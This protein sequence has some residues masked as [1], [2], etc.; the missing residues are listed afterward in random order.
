[1]RF[2]S[3]ELFIHRMTG[4]VAMLNRSAILVRPREPYLQWARELD[5]SGVV[6][7]PKAERTV[8]LVES[9]ED[10]LDADRVLRACFDLIFEEELGGWHTDE[11]AWPEDRSYEVFREWFDVEVDTMVVDLLDA[12]PAHEDLRCSP[13]AKAEGRRDSAASGRLCWPGGGSLV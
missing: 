10:D 4:E 1:M 11:A 9:I 12:P 6:P 3:A 5:D 13:M 2:V 8:Y 7:D